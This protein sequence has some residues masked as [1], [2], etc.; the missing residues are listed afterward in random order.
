[1]IGYLTPE[2][3]KAK[4]E[5]IDLSNPSAVDIKA[6]NAIYNKT[7]GQKK[8]QQKCRKT[9]KSPKLKIKVAKKID[10]YLESSKKEV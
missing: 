9:L 2:A 3:I 7:M 4:K 5:V 1:M 10:K 8:K 6:F